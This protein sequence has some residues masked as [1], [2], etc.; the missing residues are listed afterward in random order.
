M[1]ALQC[2]PEQFKG[3][4]IFMSMYNDIVWRERGNTEEC[5]MNSVAVANYARRFLLG[6][7]SFLGPGSEKKWYGTYSDKPDRDWDKTARMMLNFAESGHPFFRATSALERGEL[8][9]KAKGKKPIHFNSSEET[10]ELILRTMISVNQLS[11]YGAVADSCKE[12]SKESEVAGKLAANAME[13]PA[14][15]P[16]ADRHSNAELQGRSE[17]VQT[18]LRRRFED[19]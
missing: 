4:I 3:R 8:R 10:I 15:L 12:L 9:S 6:R 16:I 7:W 19:C 1:T 13:I 2:E 18:V 17:I 5:I 11:I 14:E